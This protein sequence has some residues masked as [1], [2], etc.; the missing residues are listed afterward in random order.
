M[1]NFEKLKPFTDKEYD[2]F[3]KFIYDYSGIFLTDKKRSLV[4]NR[5]RKRV[6]LHNFT[7][8]G[9]YFSYVKKHRDEEFVMMINV[10]TTNVS[11]FFR[12]EK[13][14]EYL[15]KEV[16]P[17][18]GKPRLK[19]WSAGCSTGEEPYSIALKLITHNP[20]VKFDI[21]ATDLS[22]RVLDFAK[23][24]LYRDEQLKTVPKSMMSNYFTKANNDKHEIKNSI[25]QNITFKQLNLIKDPFPQNLDI[26]FCRNV[27]IYFDKDTKEK[28]FVKFAKALNKDGY[29]FLGHS[30]SLFN[31]PLFKFYK[32]SLYVKKTQ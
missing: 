29:L 3:C 18:L 9:E 31:N 21:L 8:Y 17:D 27:I 10:I 25:K 7:S 13:Q 4:N 11:S 19:I 24:G 2:E 28:L 32:P 5:L 22:T 6:L 20:D 14:F 16:V 1:L 26:I 23:N 30:E 15:S 12:D